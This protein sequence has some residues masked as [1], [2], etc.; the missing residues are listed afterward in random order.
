MHYQRALPPTAARPLRDD[1]DSGPDRQP[2]RCLV[3]RGRSAPNSTPHLLS[4]TGERRREKLRVFRL[5]RCAGRLGDTAS[6]IKPRS[7]PLVPRC[8][9]RGARVSGDR[10]SVYR[11]RWERP[12]D[13]VIALHGQASCKWRPV[14]VGGQAAWLPGGLF[15][16]TPVENKNPAWRRILTGPYRAV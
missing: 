16:T 8:Q 6:P 3:Y 9:G 13:W 14:R 12:A 10:R 15:V 7:A 2:P 5:T 4:R 11:F 1:S